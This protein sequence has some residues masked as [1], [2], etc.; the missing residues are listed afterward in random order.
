M[1]LLALKHSFAAEY[2]RRAEI[3]AIV[4]CSKGSEVGGLLYS[5]AAHS[6]EWRV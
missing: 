2:I 1:F 5:P 6:V 3:S 4:G